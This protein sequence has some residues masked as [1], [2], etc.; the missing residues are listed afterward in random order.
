[1]KEM[2]KRIGG[3]PIGGCCRGKR[4][5]TIGEG[6]K[7]GCAHRCSRFENRQRGGCGV[8]TPVKARYIKVAI[9]NAGIC[10]G[11]HYGAGHPSWFFIDG[12]TVK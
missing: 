3:H 9:K 7:T 2:L 12:V 6:R 8:D 10:S 4:A 1:M 5:D 11:W